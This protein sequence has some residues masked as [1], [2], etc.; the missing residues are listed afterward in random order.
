MITK[1]VVNIFFKWSGYVIYREAC[2]TQLFNN[3]MKFKETVLSSEWIQQEHLLLKYNIIYNII[4][5]EEP[6]YITEAGLRETFFLVVV[7]IM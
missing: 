2:N 1:Y 4:Y 3:K 6:K 7:L 5:F